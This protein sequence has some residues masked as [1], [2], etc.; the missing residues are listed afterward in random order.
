MKVSG[1][2]MTMT[3]GDSEVIVIECSLEDGTEIPFLEG[4]TV[5]FTVK[6]SSL[7]DEIALQKIVTEFNEDGNCIIEIAPNDTKDLE[8]RSYVYDIQLNRHDGTV[9]TIVPCSKFT[10]LEEVTYD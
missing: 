3:R 6:R 9:T 7:V 8:F 10:V 5:Y 2:N 1:K 4:D